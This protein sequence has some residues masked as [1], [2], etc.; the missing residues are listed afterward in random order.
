M[1]AE[2]LLQY[3]TPGAL[4]EHSTRRHCGAGFA[5]SVPNNVSQITSKNVTNTANHKNCHLLVC[6]IEFIVRILLVYLYM[7]TS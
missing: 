4:Y 6:K 3:V 7:Y 5:H 1:F 2:D